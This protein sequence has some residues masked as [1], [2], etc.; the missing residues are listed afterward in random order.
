MNCYIGNTSDDQRSFMLYIQGSVCKY[1]QA[2]NST[3]HICLPC[4][5]RQLVGHGHGFVKVLHHYFY[6]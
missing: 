2:I 1:A 5:D 3:H 4:L 6:S